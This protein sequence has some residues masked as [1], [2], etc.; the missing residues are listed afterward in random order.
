MPAPRMDM[1]SE[2]AMTNT[3]SLKDRLC[4]ALGMGLV[5]RSA[6]PIALVAVFGA[7]TTAAGAGAVVVTSA[8]AANAEN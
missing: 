5:L 4:T 1:A 2:N 7:A 3:P 6:A 8:V